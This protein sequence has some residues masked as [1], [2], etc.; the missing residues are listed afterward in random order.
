LVFSVSQ[1]LPNLSQLPKRSAAFFPEEFVDAI[2]TVLVN[3]VNR[4]GWKLYVCWC[5]QQ[6][7]VK[8]APYLQ[9]DEKAFNDDLLVLIN[10]PNDAGNHSAP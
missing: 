1:Y 2:A 5:D 9:P 8:L 10:Q 7:G 6:S 3:G 4:W